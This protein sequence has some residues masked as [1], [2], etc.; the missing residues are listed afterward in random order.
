MHES[1]SIKNQ[2]ELSVKVR[3]VS[4]SLTR[5]RWTQQQPK[6]CAIH[7]DR[8]TTSLPQ[9]CSL[10]FRG[11]LGRKEV[12]IDGCRALSLEVNSHNVFLCH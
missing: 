10:C 2:E 11:S 8:L 5:P 1:K 4:A 7:P 12:G 6:S 3:Q 9:E